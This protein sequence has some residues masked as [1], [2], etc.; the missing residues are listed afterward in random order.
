MLSVSHL[1]KLYVTCLDM[2]SLE[3]KLLVFMH[4]TLRHPCTE[5]AAQ[6]LV[7]Q[8][9]WTNTNNVHLKDQFFSA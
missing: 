1:V 8:Y 5:G 6:G 7:S 2:E 4:V 3:N 9:C